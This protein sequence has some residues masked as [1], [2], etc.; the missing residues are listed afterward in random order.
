MKPA[1]RDLELARAD[2]GQAAALS[3][4]AFAAKAS[5]GYGPGLMTRWRGD[6]S[7]TAEYLQAQVVWTARVE[8]ELAGWGGTVGWGRRCRLEHLWI[9]PSQQRQGIGRILLYHLAVEARAAG[10]EELEIVADPFAA[11]FYQRCGAQPAGA[12]TLPD[13]RRLPLLILP[14]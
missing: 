7:V 8:G 11:E 14:I 4:L 6:L 5:H 13:G 9:A 10:W 3:E 12:E 2:P 1:L